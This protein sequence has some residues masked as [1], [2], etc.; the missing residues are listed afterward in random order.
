MSFSR[1]IPPNM[2]IT[3]LL[4]G[5]L[6]QLAL[7]SPSSG[8]ENPHGPFAY[9]QP[10]S[11]P[12]EL[13]AVIEIPQG[14][15]NK[16]EIDH[17]TGLLILNRVVSMP[18]AYPANYGA[19]PRTL[20]GDGDPLDLL[21]ST[22]APIQAGALVLV[23]PIGVLRM[24]DAGVQD[25]KILCVPAS[26]VDPT[27]DDI[28]TVDDLPKIEREGIEAFFRIYKDLPEGRKKVELTGFGG[29]EEA[30]KI[31]RDALDAHKAA[32]TGD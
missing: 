7:L 10:D 11:A 23:R 22:R 19:F 20:A 27:Y 6:I 9:P 14:S 13:M 25:D 28:K 31:I 3:C 8:A 2:K 18:V 4:T 15:I 32:Q 16:Y 26:K 5:F 29:V 1:E 21:V 30:H 12:N 24:I 17:A